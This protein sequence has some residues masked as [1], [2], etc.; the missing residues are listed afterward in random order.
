MV[1]N[2]YMFTIPWRGYRSQE[3]EPIIMECWIIVDRLATRF[4]SGELRR[5]C[6]LFRCSWKYTVRDRQYR[7]RRSRRTGAPCRRKY[8]THSRQFL[9]AFILEAYGAGWHSTSSGTMDPPN[10]TT[11]HCGINKSTGPS[12][13]TKSDGRTVFL[14]KQWCCKPVLWSNPDTR[15]IFAS[16]QPLRL[17]LG[18]S[19]HS[20]SL[21][22]R[23]CPF[24]RSFRIHVHLSNVYD[25][26]DFTTPVEYILDSTHNSVLSLVEC[27]RNIR[28]HR[29]SLPT[30]ASQC[31]VRRR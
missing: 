27:G 14:R 7:E 29:T 17:L 1:P 23:F 6:Q 26:V 16:Q 31:M 10:R 11:R 28:N 30:S 15:W 3:I 19:R 18:I 22:P 13:W 8:A 12:S 20:N 2:V 5:N 4:T 9:C 21:P 24:D 25:I